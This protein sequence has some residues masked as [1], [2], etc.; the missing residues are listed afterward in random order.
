MITINTLLSGSNMKKLVNWL[1][2]DHSLTTF[3]TLLGIELILSAWWF[4]PREGGHWDVLSGLGIG[5]LTGA[6]INW[7]AGPLKEKNKP[8]D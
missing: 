5:V 7:S 6:L 2:E 8:E 3:L 1:V 4:T